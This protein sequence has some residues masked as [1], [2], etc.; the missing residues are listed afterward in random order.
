[1][2]EKNL[3]LIITALR[4]CKAK[5]HGHGAPDEVYESWA[6]QT[7]L[8]TWELVRL[9]QL[10]C[11]VFFEIEPAF[12]SEALKLISLPKEEFNKIKRNETYW[13]KFADQIN[14][15]AATSEPTQL[16]ITSMPNFTQSGSST[17]CPVCNRTH[18]DGCSIATDG[19][20]VLCRS[21]AHSG[22]VAQPLDEVNGY[23]FTGKINGSGVLERAV[24]VLAKKPASTA[25]KDLTFYYPDSDGG[26]CVRTRRVDQGNGKKMIW[27]E[28]W[29]DDPLLTK[30][31][32]TGRWVKLSEKAVKDGKATQEERALYL[33]YQHE[34][35]AQVHLY[36]IDEAHKLAME[37]SLPLFMVEGETSAQALMDLGIPATTA[38]GGAGKFGHYGSV[39]YPADLARFPKVVICP[40]CDRDGIKHAEQIAD[41][42]PEAQ[43]LYA[44]PKHPRW[45]ALESGYDVKNWIED[46]ATADQILAAVEPRRI[47]ALI[48]VPT[49]SAGEESEPVAVQWEKVPHSINHYLHRKETRGVGEN[50][51]IVSVPITNFDFTVERVL[52]SSTG[53]GLALAVSRMVAGK[54]QVTRVIVDSQKDCGKPTDFAAG[55]KRGLGVNIVCNLKPDEFGALLAVRTEDYHIK[56]GRTY[57]LIDRMGQQEDGTWVTEEMQFTKDGEVTSEEQTGWVFNPQLSEEDFIPHPLWLKP[58]KEAIPNLV[59]AAYEFFHEQ[60]FMHFLLDCGWAA[61]GVHYAKIMEEE[62]AFPLLNNYGDKG[63][64]KTTSMAAALSLVGW[65]RN[66]DRSGIVSKLSQSALYERLKCIGS[67]PLLWDDPSKGDHKEQAKMDEMLKT[68]YNGEARVVRGNT[69]KPHSPLAVTTN[70]SLG[71]D[72]AA[73]RSRLMMRY[74]PTLPTNGSEAFRKLSAAMDQASAGFSDLIKIGYPKLAVTALEDELRTHLGHADGRIVKSMALVVYYADRIAKLA[75]ITADLRR[76]AIDVLCPAENDAET[77]KDSLA[78]FINKLTAL[79]SS[80]KV[81]EWSCRS[82][83]TTKGRFVA[84]HMPSIWK[85]FESA[86]NPIYSQNVI[87]RLVEEQG[88]T[89]SSTQKFPVTADLWRAYEREQLKGEGMCDAPEMITRKCILLPMSVAAPLMVSSTQSPEDSE[90]V[91][92]NNPDSTS[93]SALSYSSYSSY[94]KIDRYRDIDRACETS[95]NSR[96]CEGHVFLEGDLGDSGKLEP[97]TQSGQEFSPVTSTEIQG[98]SAASPVTGYGI[99]SIGTKVWCAGQEHGVIVGFDPEYEDYIVRLASGVEEPYQVS[100]LEVVI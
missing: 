51:Y 91:T 94:L 43:W 16:E 77:S 19:K 74:F 67:L 32:T 11:D 4:D 79:Q 33:K 73:T 15:V 85:E 37:T 60:T 7:G 66:G 82:V 46:G 2:T 25:K 48:A 23:S 26:H 1:M 41:L 89:I 5:S 50:S 35:A 28:Y 38:I 93:T 14:P 65:Q 57:K 84:L 53:G 56:G 62:K 21:R 17:P 3:A 27:Q 88:G 98:D 31:V 55:I 78:D 92:E 71:D 47:A 6:K 59:Q 95:D 8:K 18:D 99:I 34:L 76:F 70:H 87:R 72:S 30:F 68:L 45:L 75:G 49:V 69:Q 64:G 24:Y 10:S 80:G 63:T 97:E 42:R 96:A 39:N 12:V 9:W 58:N 81:G 100:L 61:A 44:N 20:T 36:Q 40:D 29:I 86:F 83:E 13:Q 52:Q 90:K 22:T 54:L